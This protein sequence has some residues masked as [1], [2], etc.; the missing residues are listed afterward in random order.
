M[1]SRMHPRL[2]LVDD[3]IFRW[4]GVTFWTLIAHHVLSCLCRVCGSRKRA[5]YFKKCGWPYPLSAHNIC[6][7][8]DGWEPSPQIFQH[9]MQFSSVFNVSYVETATGGLALMTFAS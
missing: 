4:K 3:L 7:Y 9:N 8:D 5:Q 6:E 1:N 2:L